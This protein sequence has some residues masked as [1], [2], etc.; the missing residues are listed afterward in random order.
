MQERT[1]TYNFRAGLIEFADRVVRERIG[2]YNFSEGL[3][4]CSERVAQ[5]AEE[6]GNRASQWWSKCEFVVESHRVPSSGLT[7]RIGTYKERIGT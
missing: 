1:G 3:A 7:E 2:T 4:I 6:P 5:N